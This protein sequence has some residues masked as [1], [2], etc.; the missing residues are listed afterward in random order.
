MT[1]YQYT[2]LK[3]PR[4][5]ADV[6]YHY[7]LKPERNPKVLADQLAHCVRKNGNEALEQVA[8][9]HPD[10]PLFQK[11]LDG[12]KEKYKKESMSN[13]CGCSN[14]SNANGEPTTSTPTNDTENRKETLIIGGIIV[15]ALAL[16]MKK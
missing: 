13:A 7:G 10:L 3:N 15:L 14:F 11:Q 4:G 5:A 12:F 9:I 6:V 1:V 8:S 16:I 2:A